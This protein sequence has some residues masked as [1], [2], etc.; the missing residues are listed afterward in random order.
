MLA[1]GE[2]PGSVSEKVY[3]GEGI[4]PDTSAPI[5]TL[6]EK[7]DVPDP[8]QPVLIRARIHDNKSPTM[9]QDW[10]TVVLRW[11]A[12][13]QVEDVPMQ[14]Y[15]EYLW[16]ATIN[17]PPASGFTYEICAADASGNEA[18]ASP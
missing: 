3:F 2:V 14:W 5:I 1:Q 17:E 6:V 8:N 13:G 15:G 10:R 7:I 18:C 9:P 4:L 11:I 16:R 12:G